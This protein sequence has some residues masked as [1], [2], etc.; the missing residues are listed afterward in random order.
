MMIGARVSVQ[1]RFLIPATDDALERRITSARMGA[2]DEHPFL[3]R[4]GPGRAFLLSFPPRRGFVNVADDRCIF[5]RFVAVEIVRISEIGDY[6]TVVLVAKVRMQLALDKEFGAAPFNDERLLLVISFEYVAVINVLA[7]LV[8]EVGELLRWLKV[9]DIT[10]KGWRDI[11]PHNDIS[12][13]YS[14]KIE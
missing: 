8:F 7:V 3:Q 6:P 11:F 14:I 1:S 5:D 12:L 13:F 4:G 10:R 2:G 9:G